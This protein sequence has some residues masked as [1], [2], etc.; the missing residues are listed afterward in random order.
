MTKKKETGRP[1]WAP[2]DD[3]RETAKIMKAQG[4][5]HEV[6]AAALGVSEPT[7]RKHLSLDLDIAI[8][9]KTAEV[10][11]ARFKSAVA[12]NV[13]AQNKFLEL[14]GTV[15]D[16]SKKRVKKEV[17]GKKEQADIDA[18][19]AHANTSWGDVLDGEKLQ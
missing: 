17:L 8:A 10:M 11:K 7:L 1:A 15:P 4:A 9:E 12:G 18:Q 2:S 5:S 3:D 6:I 19:S 16:V 14:A 13:T